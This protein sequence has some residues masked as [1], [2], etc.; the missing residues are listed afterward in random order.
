MGN[1]RL[2][3]MQGEKHIHCLR[4]CSHL[5][6]FLTR[7]NCFCS[8]IKSWCFGYKAAEGVFCC[9]NSSCNG[10]LARCAAE[11]SAFEVNGEGKLCRFIMTFVG[12]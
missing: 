5:V 8:K 1:E 4:A 7:R 6:S 3:C 11:M 10:S 12:A 2:T 9:Y